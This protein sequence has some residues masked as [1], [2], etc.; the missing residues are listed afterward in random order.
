MKA[1]IL[2]ESIDKTHSDTLVLSFFKDERPLRG[3][4]GLIDWRLCGRV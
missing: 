3:A 4:N 2:S 1:K